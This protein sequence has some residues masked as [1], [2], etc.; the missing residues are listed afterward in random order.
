MHR[1]VIAAWYKSAL[2]KHL[3][4]LSFMYII[5][6][7]ISL[8]IAFMHTAFAPWVAPFTNNTQ[9]IGIDIYNNNHISIH[10]DIMFAWMATVQHMYDA[11]MIHTSLLMSICFFMIAS[12]WFPLFHWSNWWW[13]QCHLSLV[14]YHVCLYNGPYRPTQ[15]GM[16][17]FWQ[18][19]FI[20]VITTF[21]FFTPWRSMP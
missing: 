9:Y 18:S 19:F 1:Y 3:L 7:R 16:C 14:I 6:V 20:N 17:F 13:L 2:V 21:W 10:N 11:S 12:A 4:I 8:N 5:T 15:P